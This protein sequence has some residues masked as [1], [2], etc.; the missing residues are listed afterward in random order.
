MLL[1]YCP[2]DRA[3]TCTF[4]F[5]PFFIFVPSPKCKCV[6]TMAE[7]SEEIFHKD[8]HTAA[9]TFISV[10]DISFCCYNIFLE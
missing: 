8:L 9:F 10:T 5:D 6:S 3:Y 7:K 2:F 1:C 4:K